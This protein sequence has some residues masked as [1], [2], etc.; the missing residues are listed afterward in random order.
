MFGIGWRRAHAVR[1]SV[2]STKHCSLLCAV[3]EDRDCC[4]GSKCVSWL[5]DCEF[6]ELSPSTLSH[7]AFV[8][9][10][11]WCKKRLW[12]SHFWVGA[13]VF[14]STSWG[15]LG[16]WQEV[17]GINEKYM[18]Y[19]AVRGVFK[20]SMLSAKARL[21]WSHCQTSSGPSRVQYACWKKNNIRRG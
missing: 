2:N 17:V 3:M 18:E 19:P 7:V 20:D 6:S 13:N 15:L 16:K 11:E 8:A 1:N 9:V 12:I 21:L 10:T 5:C 14:S 4:S